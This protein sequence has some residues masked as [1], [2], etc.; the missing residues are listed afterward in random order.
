ME[1]QKY[2]LTVYFSK[3]DK[4]ETQEM[5]KIVNNNL[6][7]EGIIGT[8]NPE[9]ENLGNNLNYYKVQYH[10]AFDIVN[11]FFNTIIFDKQKVIFEIKPIN[12]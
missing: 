3:S 9:Q 10:Q 1:M 2:N 5:S 6:G 8:N 7:L 12:K 4:I 11:Y